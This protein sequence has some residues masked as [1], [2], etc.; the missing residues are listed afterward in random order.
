MSEENPLRMLISDPDGFFYNSYSG[1]SF[2][3]PLFIVTILVLLSIFRTVLVLA[4]LGDSRDTGIT[5][6]ILVS[7]FFGATSAY[8]IWIAISA[9]FHVISSYFTTSGSF[10]KTVKMVGWGFFPLVI[11]GLI[12][13]FASLMVIQNMSPGTSSQADMILKMYSKLHIW[14]YQTKSGSCS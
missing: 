6:V 12:S 11:S 13:V 3:Y 10:R 2:K 14:K 9:L 1:K 7:I 5:I 8:L 4:L